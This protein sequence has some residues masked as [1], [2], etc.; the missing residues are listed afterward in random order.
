MSRS[1][2]FSVV[3]SITEDQ[4]KQFKHMS[5]QIHT[6]SQRVDQAHSL[7]KNLRLNQFNPILHTPMIKAPWLCTNSLTTFLKL[8]TEQLTGSFKA[9]GALFFCHNAVHNDIN[10]IVTASTGNHAMGIV[11]ALSSVTD[12][13]RDPT[14]HRTSRTPTADIYVPNTCVPNKLRSLRSAIGNSTAVKIKLEGNDCVEAEL[15]ALRSCETTNSSTTD[16]DETE[17]RQKTVYVSPYNNMDVMAGNGT[18][19]NEILDDLQM[20]IPPHKL[21]NAKFTCYVTVGGGGLISGIAAKLKTAQPGKWRVVGCL[22]QNSPVMYECLKHGKVIDIAS[23]ATLSD[24]S[25]G[26]LEPETQTLELCANL[27]DAWA[28]VSELEIGNAM[29]RVFSEQK[30]VLEGAAGVAVAGFFRDASWRKQNDCRVAIIVACGTNVEVD[31]F[32]EVVNG[33]Y[34]YES[35]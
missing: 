23:K 15:A 31:S 14:K 30:K 2:D 3:Q 9:R 24:G 25:A 22:P 5:E 26:G 13:Y 21:Q 10:R 7:F 29:A 18:V 6:L 32:I 19:A 20:F 12:L 11:H 1:D 35:K 17:K 33:K 27:V 34:N 28:L 4:C 8:E 16:I